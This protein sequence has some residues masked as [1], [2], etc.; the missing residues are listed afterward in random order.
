MTDEQNRWAELN[1]QRDGIGVSLYEQSD[2]DDRAI[3]VDETWLTRAELE[4][5][6]VTEQDGTIILE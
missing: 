5:I 3:V 2:E 4:E 6:R 1:V